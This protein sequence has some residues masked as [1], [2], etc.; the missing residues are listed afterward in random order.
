M[1]VS[2]RGGREKRVAGAIRQLPFARLVNPYTPIGILSDDQVEAIIDGA[3]T[4]LETRGMRFLE[5]GSR[6]LLA[7]AGAE[8]VDDAGT[9][10]ID[11]GLVKD[12]RAYLREAA[13]SHGHPHA[14]TRGPTARNAIK[15][16]I[17]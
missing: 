8:F 2:R 12:L 13:G 1:T 17:Q 7:T 6:K 14:A 3:F 4:I 9:M 11:R 5:P 15:G 16:Q 10:H